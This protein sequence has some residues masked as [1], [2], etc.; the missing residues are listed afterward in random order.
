MTLQQRS[1]LP[2]PIDEDI[3]KQL[4][5]LQDRIREKFKRLS[6]APTPERDQF[7]KIVDK[8]PDGYDYIKERYMRALLNKEF[9]GWSAENFHKEIVGDWL[10]G[11]LELIIIVPELL[12]FGIIP[13]VRRFPGAG[14]ARITFKS[15][16]PHTLENVVDMDK[17]VK[18]VRSTALKDAINRA[19]GIGDDIYGKRV[20]PESM[21]SEEEYIESRIFS[22]DGGS[23]AM[24]MEFVSKHYKPAS[25]AFS[26][27]GITDFGEITTVEQVQEAYRKIQEDKGL[28]EVVQ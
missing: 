24:L 26:V 7:G 10:I 22:G 5:N 9:P 28:K 14:A 27:L 18:A 23:K 1:P 15:G 6:D 8:R 2:I 16:M 4:E 25:K 12:A 3:L 17:N 20:D 11:D 13:P 19:T 21:G